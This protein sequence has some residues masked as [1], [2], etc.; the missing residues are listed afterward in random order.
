[1]VGVGGGRG[2]DASVEAIAQRNFVKFE[3][4]AQKRSLVKYTLSVYDCD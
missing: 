3:L 4:R 1:M 2:G